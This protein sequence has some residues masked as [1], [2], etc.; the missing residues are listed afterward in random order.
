MNSW[1]DCGSAYQLPGRSRTGTRKSRAPSGVDRVRYG[2]LHVHEPVVAH[3]VAEQVGGRGPDP[4]RARDLL[5]ADVQVAVLDPDVLADLGGA[6][7]RERQRVGL[8]EHLDRRGD[9]LD[10]AGGQLGVLVARPAA[11]APRRSP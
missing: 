7:D 5:A 8:A 11:A 4:Q 9:D 3:D 6:L 10:R 2:R 1:G